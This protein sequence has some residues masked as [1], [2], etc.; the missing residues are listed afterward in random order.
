MKLSITLWKI[1]HSTNHVLTPC[2]CRTQG[3]QVRR[4]LPI[5]QLHL[6]VYLYINS[7]DWDYFHLEQ[8]SQPS[9][10]SQEM[11]Y[12]NYMGTIHGTHGM[13]HLRPFQRSLSQP[14]P[15]IWKRRMVRP[16]KRGYRFILKAF[17]DGFLFCR[18]LTVR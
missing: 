3:S 14:L 6:C 8:G 9:F 5:L 13:Q 10:G 2:C 17:V 1:F 11:E 18:V 4:K 7:N 15:R 16:L 12:A